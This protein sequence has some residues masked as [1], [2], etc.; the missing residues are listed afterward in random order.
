MAGDTLK[1][2]LTALIQ[3]ALGENLAA[4]KIRTRGG[5]SRISGLRPH[6]ASPTADEIADDLAQQ[7][8][9]S[10]Y[11][12]SNRSIETIQLAGGNTAEMVAVLTL[13]APFVFKL[14][15][16]DKKLA[17]EGKLMR[18]IKE[19]SLPSQFKDAWPIVYAV[20]D[21][22]PYAYL[23]EYF[24]TTDGWQSLEDRLYSR[25]GEHVVS[26][27]QAVRMVHT[28]LDVLFAGYEA[29]LNVRARPSLEA[30][31]VGRIRD[32]LAAAA[33]LDGRFQSQPLLINGM[34]YQPWKYYLDQ[35]SRNEGL[36]TR[37]APP[38]MT[39]AHGDPNPGNL[40]LRSHPSGT[41]VKLIDP[42]EWQTGDYLFDIAKLTHFFEATGP[43]EQTG[44]QA[45]IVVAFVE[46]TTAATLN[47]NFE[48]PTWTGLLV[49]ACLGRVEQFAVAKGDLHWAARYDLAMAANLLGLPEGRLKRGRGEVA[50]ALYGEGIRALASFCAR[51]Q[52][53]RPA[54]WT[55][56][57][58][59]CRSEVEP[60]FIS[61]ARAQ[62]RA[63]VPN[64]REGEDRRGFKTLHWDSPRPNKEG[65]PIEL[66][67]EHEAR[68]MPISDSAFEHLQRSLAASDGKPV[69]D[70]LLPQ[71]PAF[72]SL[73]LRRYKRETGFQSVD[74]YWELETST[75]EAQLIPRMLSLRERT[76]ASTIMTWCESGE[77]R[78]LNLELPLIALEGTGV[79]VRLEFNW[80]DEIALSLREF[81]IGGENGAE[82]NAIMLASRI[83]PIERG[84]FEPVIEHTTFREKYA[85]RAPDVGTEEGPEL[86]QLNIDRVVAQSLR[87]GRIAS[88]V[89]VDIAP[90][91]VVDAEV[92]ASLVA[93]SQ[94]LSTRFELIPLGA[95]KVW[96]D[97]IMTDSLGRR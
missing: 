71:D 62:V 54:I 19:G 11:P 1:G 42:K 40:M 23:M 33:G 70:G 44:S 80:I 50:L 51:L 65:K 53:E 7:A 18:E 72:G 74:R 86:F 13:N 26:D 84:V 41:E 38:F 78:A 56:V 9:A 59:A 90:A 14:D 68:L 28:V 25:P 46:G 21:V 49:E 45:S 92:L 55:V 30:D 75:A 16:N 96:R 2:A 8:V 64:A 6:P 39:V 24:P 4:P 34:P 87:T 3:E 29:S 95:T 58:S 76:S 12:L 22:A 17:A 60:K 37:I 88:Y 83:V 48:Q 57:S 69:G 79:V 67:L 97:A 36:I 94:A 20:R 77:K 31:Y 85:L 61:D 73:I 66:S 81:S 82:T 93:L 15:R 27:T 63:H 52:P 91:R 43:I 47:Y 5:S 32:R 89:D 10:G 35:L